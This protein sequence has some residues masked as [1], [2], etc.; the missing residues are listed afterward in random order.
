MVA[1]LQSFPRLAAFF[2]CL[3]FLTTGCVISGTNN[4]PSPSDQDLIKVGVSANAP[5]FA[6]KV[7]GKL[8]GL[9][10]DFANQLGAYLDKKVTFIE[11]PWD[12]QLSSLETGK[13]DI[14]MS[15]MTI[16]PK[17]QYRVSF[18]R[19]YLKSGQMLLV[20]ASQA[21]RYA[22][23]IFSLMGEQPAI[24]TIEGTTGDLFIT[25]TINK[26]RLT[27]Y[28]KSKQAVDALIKE[29]V[30]VLVHDAPIVC[31][32]AATTESA[33]LTPI[34]QLAT[35]EYLAWAINKNNPELLGKAN[36]FLAAENK[37]QRLQKTI[38]RWIPFMK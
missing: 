27:R 12:K 36:E 16:T 11:V 5:P 23:G 2:A 15:G 25:K 20:R 37:S 33:R 19:A 1:I 9:E 38:H 6:Y 7:N 26:P 3:V 22:S 29:E 35:E 13:T 4:A 14:I 24:A 32:Y 31:H 10:I 21:N 28:K 17:R 30:D 8:Q 18:T 34:L